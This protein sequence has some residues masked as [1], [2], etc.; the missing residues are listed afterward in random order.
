[1]ITLDLI[2]DNI[3]YIK[4]FFLD[5]LKYINTSC[6]QSVVLNKIIT[7]LVIRL[8]IGELNLQGIDSRSFYSIVNKEV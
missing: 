4:F 1:M 6:M 8:V 5:H 3:F 7:F 2:F